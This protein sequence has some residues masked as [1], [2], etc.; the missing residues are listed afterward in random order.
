MVEYIGYKTVAVAIALIVLQ[1]VLTALRFISRHVGKTSCGWDDAFI[2]PSLLFCWGTCI[3]GIGNASNHLSQV[4][5]HILSSSKLILHQVKV[6]VGGV[7][8]HQPA[9]M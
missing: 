9:L 2:I 5:R 6:E 1:G 4:Q 7:G 3:L 8:G